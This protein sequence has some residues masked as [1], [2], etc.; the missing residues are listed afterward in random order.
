MDVA[1][2]KTNQ[3]R[4]I[5]E[6]IND[7]RPAWLYTI[8]EGEEKLLWHNPAA[9]LL[10]AQEKKGKLELSSR[11]CAQKGQI[12]K[13]FQL[14]S[15]ARKFL[16]RI[17]FS[18]SKSDFFLTCTY[19]PLLIN[20]EKFIFITGVDAIDGALF[21]KFS[22][23][24]E[25]LSGLFDKN[26][27]LTILDKD[28]ADNILH[29]EREKINISLANGQEILLF[30]D[31]I[32]PQETKENKKE[33]KTKGAKT[34]GAKTKGAETKGAETEKEKKFDSL[35]SL[36]DKLSADEEL[37]TP[38]G[39]QDDEILKQTANIEP[40]K[41][42]NSSQNKTVLY[43]IIGEGFEKLEETN[44]QNSK[45]NEDDKSRYNFT[46]LAKMLNQRINSGDRNEKENLAQSDNQLNIAA[47]SSSLVKIPEE[48]QILNR[49][50]L[51]LLIFRDDKILFC[52]RSMVDLLGYKTGP[53]LRQTPL[54][55]IFPQN[56][57][58]NLGAGPLTHLL[59]A[60]GEKIAVNA[61]LQ[62]VMFNSSAALMLSA[63]KN[64]QESGLNFDSAYQFA[65]NIAE[66][67]NGGALQATKAGNLI[68]YSDN[69]PLLFNRY[70]DN[71]KNYPLS[72]LVSDEEV[73]K[74]Q[75]FLQQ[76]DKISTGKEDKNFAIS[77]KAIE[78]NIE[79]LLF[80]M[81]RTQQDLTYLGLVR[82]KLAQNN[83]EPANNYGLDILKNLSH[84]LRGPLN[85]IIGFS[86]LLGNKSQAKGDERRNKEYIND[87]NLAGKDIL[88]T[89]DEL[90]EFALLNSQ[91]YE[92][93]FQDL[94]LSEILEDCL[95]QIRPHANNLRV[96][97]R[98]AFA[99][100]LGRIRGDK[101]SLKQA[102]LNLLANAI[103]Q[104]PMGGLIIVSAKE[105]KDKTLI[106]HVR[107]GGVNSDEY[108]KNFA[109]FR[110]NQQ[111]QR[112]IQ[113]STI[114]NMGLMLTQSLLKVNSLS[115]EIDQTH[116]FGTIASLIIP[117]SMRIG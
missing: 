88:A 2:I 59:S 49:L 62:S 103:E 3:G 71:L 46:E 96:L 9:R 76:D 41:E 12:E 101:K 102:V 98:S 33:A 36:L 42:D 11:T 81:P 28:K 105:E 55:N 32:K 47:K 1:W 37:F 74:L 85:T 73:E 72:L 92:A 90:E 87:I 16:A 22:Y 40:D 8:R 113:R 20:G 97:V 13:F 104:T 99:P 50:S 60:K 48:R 14:G 26:I 56:D 109:L 64:E 44:E 6:Y 58:E 77:L 100:N 25:I 91:Q 82:K 70:G 19:M 114:S 24:S 31:E 69:L 111:P 107:D 43:K 108:K 39:E 65:L 63:S 15:I 23:N 61:R 7:P 54:G 106:I 18:N 4:K 51:A 35:T 86:E 94:E 66:I 53:A 95:F 17:K 79:I 5:L 57:D 80:K 117:A 38:L 116:N 10:K 83:N 30:L 34:K 89:I 21:G 115:L 84:S 78:E 45:P 110:E 67:E 68:K 29:E 112:Q 93:D 27:G 75:Q 52:N